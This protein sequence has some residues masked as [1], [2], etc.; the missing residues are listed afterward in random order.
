MLAGIG[1]L[2]VDT[3][4]E[5]MGMS[6]LCMRAGVVAVHPAF[7]GII[8]QKERS[9]MDP[10]QRKKMNSCF[11]CNRHVSLFICT[12]ALVGLGKMHDRGNLGMSI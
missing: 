1:C 3:P 10:S 6:N 12:V 4:H 5:W 9:E 11:T 2:Y 8:V 7:M